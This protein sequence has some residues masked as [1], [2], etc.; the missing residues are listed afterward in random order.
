D[1]DMR[2][3]FDRE[4][5]VNTYWQSNG[6]LMFKR[7]Q[8]YFPLMEP[9]LASN[10]VPDD[11][12]YLAVIESGLDQVVSPAGATGFWQFMK[13]T[14]KEYGLEVNSNVDERYHV[15][16]QTQAAAEYLKKAK[17]R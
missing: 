12:K 9:I 6:L 14:A 8:E 5:L 13:T 15:E 10:G 3:R 1:P 11:F 4:L 7:A 17:E 2:K 16:K